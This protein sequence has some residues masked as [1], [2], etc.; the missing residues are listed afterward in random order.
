MR[1]GIAKNI[2]R[3]VWRLKIVEKLCFGRGCHGY[4]A[5]PK[6]VFATL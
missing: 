1:T 2:E 4:H 5:W 6:I 3:A